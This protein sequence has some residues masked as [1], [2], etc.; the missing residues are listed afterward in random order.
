MIDALRQLLPKLWSTNRRPTMSSREFPWTDWRA[1]MRL[2]EF[3]WSDWR[4]STSTL[5]TLCWCR[6]LKIGVPEPGKTHR[7]ATAC[8][9]RF[10]LCLR[11]P[12]TT[13]PHFSYCFLS[14]P[15]RI[16]PFGLSDRSLTFK[17]ECGLYKDTMGKNVLQHKRVISFKRSWK[18]QYN[19]LDLRNY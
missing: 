18:C 9:P 7:T 16:L 15:N 1:S 2:P 12:T 17:N 6:R 13:I 4:P 11:R 10:C 5:C 8:L 14:A 19:E 3:P